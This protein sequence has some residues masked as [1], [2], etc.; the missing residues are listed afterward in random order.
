VLDSDDAAYVAGLCEYNVIVLE[1]DREKGWE[2]APEPYRYLRH[3]PIIWLRF[4]ALT[5]LRHKAQYDGKVVYLDADTIVRRSLHEAVGRCAR[6]VCGVTGSK[7]DA[8]AI[9]SGVLVFDLVEWSRDRVETCPADKSLLSND[10]D[11]LYCLY[12][13]SDRQL[14]PPEWNVMGLGERRDIPASLLNQAAVLHWT[15]IY[16]PW[17]SKSGQAY[18]HRYYDGQL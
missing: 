1:T 7:T 10:M 9:N 5:Y 16:K 3:S 18:Y 11:L 15:G 6:P 8:L 12:P 4:D 13:P 17:K 14:L 2:E